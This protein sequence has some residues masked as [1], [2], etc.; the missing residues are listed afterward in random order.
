MRIRFL[1]V[2]VSAGLIGGGFA[3][4]ACGGT[5]ETTA[6]SDAGPD[7]TV[8]TGIKDSSLPDTRDS[9]P[10]C[11]PNRDFLKDIPDASIADGA[12]TT[13]ICVGCAKQKC[14]SDIDKCAANC[15]CQNIASGALDCYLKT[16][17]IT[18]GSPFFSAGTETREYRPR[19]GWLHPVGL[20]GRVRGRLVQPGRG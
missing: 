6:V 16:Q 9:A 12:T 18:C 5:E 11:D 10:E 1:L 19:S 7:V 13:G 2:C 15:K 4:Q 17:A 20:Q 8:D 14:K 3:I